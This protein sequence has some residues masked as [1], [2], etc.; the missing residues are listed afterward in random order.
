MKNSECRTKTS[1]RNDRVVRWVA[2]SI[3]GVLLAMV[4]SA[5]PEGRHQ[6]HRT[7]P[8][9]NLERMERLLDL[10]PDQ[11]EALETV[12]ETHRTDN[13]GDRE[14]QRENRM[15]VKEALDVDT[16]D[17]L[18]VGQLVIEG[19]RLR[20]AGKESHETLQAAVAEVLTDEQE[21][22]WEGFLSGRRGGRD[23]GPGRKRG[24]GPGRFGGPPR[25]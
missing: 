1:A 17:A 21:A 12:F 8:G 25:G 24:P 7:E 23:G 14:A 18:T 9:Q 4:A 15:A 5:Q 2:T 3:L 10:A 22:K 11:V 20:E 13:Q 19:K 16:P 6:R